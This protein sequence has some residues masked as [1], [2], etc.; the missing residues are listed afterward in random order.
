VTVDEPF[1]DAHAT[2]GTLHRTR[3]LFIVGSSRGGGRR[4]RL[5]TAD[6]PLGF[7]AAAA[8][9]FVVHQVHHLVSRR[10]VCFQVR[11]ADHIVIL[12]LLLG[13]AVVDIARLALV[14]LVLFVRRVVF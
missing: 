14:V 2:D 3:S 1:L 13:S 7:A 11:F 10:R 6:F 9:V 4:R 8:S 12:V 5:A